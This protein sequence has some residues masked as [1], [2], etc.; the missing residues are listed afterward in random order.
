MDIVL[1]L[2]TLALGFFIG[3]Y[4][5]VT[6]ALHLDRKEEERSRREAVAAFAEQFGVS[7]EEADSRVVSSPP[8][9]Y[10]YN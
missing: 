6:V 4:T 9:P 1:Y 3:A 7:L 8:P 10:Y 5:V 2:T